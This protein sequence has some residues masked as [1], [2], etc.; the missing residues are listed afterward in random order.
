VYAPD[1]PSVRGKNYNYVAEHRLVMEGIL[2]RYLNPW[3][4]VHHKDT[5]RQNNEPDNLEFWTV[6]QPAGQANVYLNE[7]VQ[8]KRE[9]AAL[10]AINT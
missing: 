5:D 7:I 3:E 10:K 9:I 8:L 6:N 1:H 4:N 2:G